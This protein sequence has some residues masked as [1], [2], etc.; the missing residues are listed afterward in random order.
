MPDPLEE[1]LQQRALLQQHLDWL[2][3]KIADTTKD[4][5]P[6]PTATPSRQTDPRGTAAPQA[7]LAKTDATESDLEGLADLEDLPPQYASTA[8]DIERLKLGCIVFF[9]AAIL[10]FLF[11]LF[12]LPFLIG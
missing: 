2:D 9:A 1:L 7:P 3:R 10:L 8:T 12:G 5:P 4:Q 11:L 6:E